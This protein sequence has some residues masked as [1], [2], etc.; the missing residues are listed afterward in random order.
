VLSHIVERKRIDDLASSI[1]DGRF[2]E[3]K[4]DFL[5]VCCCC[6]CCFALLIFLCL[7]SSV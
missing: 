4:V 5:F 6:C 7:A 2:K 1:I 3:Q